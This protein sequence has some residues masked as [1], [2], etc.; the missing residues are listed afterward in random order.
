[1]RAAQ[2]NSYGN[3]DAM[4]T[5]ADAPKPQAAPGQ[6]LVAVHSA[7]VNPFDWKVREGFMQQWAPLTFPATL[8]GDFSGVIVAL[9]EGVTDFAVGQEVFGE[10]NSVGGNGSFAEFAPIPVKT[11]A[12]KPQNLSFTQ[13][14]ALPL[15][16][17]SA[18]LAVV[19][20]LQVQAGQR[21]LVH[22]GAGGIG[23]FAIQIAKHLG[24]HVATTAKAANTAYVTELG[25]DEVIDYQTEQFDQKLRDFDA[26]FDTVGGE[27]YTRSFGVLKSGGHIASMVEKNNDELA[28][29]HNVTAHY[30]S[31]EATH[32]RLQHIVE[33]LD[34][35]AIKVHVDKTFPLEQAA[36]AL[37][38][39][40]T[41]QHKG[42][43][44]ITVQD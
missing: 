29:R 34:K 2:I 42:K 26:V 23:S 4:A 30:I 12:L 44:V 14:A 20:T 40:K 28:Q 3:K 27:T 22:G 39:V 31:S 36:E 25:A 11:L 5:T 24:A 33:L 1:M 38:Y 35:G 21:I 6:V 19:E 32:D 41:G 10:A 18:Y 13:A 9:G 43:V 8:G 37:E 16:S 15:A 17:A 7:G